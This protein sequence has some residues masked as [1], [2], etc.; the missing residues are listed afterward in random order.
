M[1]LPASVLSL[2]VLGFFITLFFVDYTNLSFKNN[3]IQYVILIASTLGGIAI[4][5]SQKIRARTRVV[6][7]KVVLFLTI[8]WFLGLAIF[9]LFTENFDIPYLSL[10]SGILVIIAMILTIKKPQTTDV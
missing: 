6:L 1:K 10:L 5:L 9:T 3:Y 7:A 2:F 4:I 8:L